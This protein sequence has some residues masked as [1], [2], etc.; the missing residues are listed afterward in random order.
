MNYI[1]CKG[2]AF[3]FGFFVFLW[4]YGRHYLN[5]VFL[6]SVLTSFK[7]IGSYDLS[8]EKGYYKCWISQII[9]FI[10][11][12]ALQIVNIY[13]LSLI[14]RIAYRFVLYGEAKDDRSDDEDEKSL[15]KEKAQ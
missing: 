14:L 3:V 4:I 12:S 8:W 10:L 2:Q 11:L 1:Q 9:I 7:N 5:I 15:T 6:Y 13:W